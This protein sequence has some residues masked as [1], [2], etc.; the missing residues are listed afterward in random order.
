MSTINKGEKYSEKKYFFLLA[1]K[2]KRY[3]SFGDS[4]IQKVEHRKMHRATLSNFRKVRYV[5]RAKNIALGDLFSYF[6]FSPLNP[7]F[8][9]PL[10]PN[11]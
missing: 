5:G 4:S 2:D 10:I 8:L 3:F 9:A 7:Q 1:K 11:F 6:I